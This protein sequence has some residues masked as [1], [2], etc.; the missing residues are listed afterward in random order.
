MENLLF[1]GVP[2]LKHI[3]VYCIFGIKAKAV[4]GEA[5]ALPFISCAQDIVGL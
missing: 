3:M 5:W 2:V 4:K 1:L